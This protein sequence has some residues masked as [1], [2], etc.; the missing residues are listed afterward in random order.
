[1]DQN[2]GLR[3]KCLMYIEYFWVLSVQVQFGVICYFSDRVHVVSRKR[4]I[5]ERNGPNLGLRGK[6]L[7]CIEYLTVKC[8][9]SVWGHSVHFYDLVSTFDLNIRDLCTAKF[10]H[11][12]YSFNYQVTKQSVK[13]S[14]PLVFFA[15]YFLSFADHLPFFAKYTCTFLLWRAFF[16]SAGLFFFSAEQFS[17]LLSICLLQFYAISSPS[18]VFSAALGAFFFFSRQRTK[19]LGREKVVGREEKLLA[20]EGKC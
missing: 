13:A 11:Y 5:I 2:L 7:V 1:M 3:D 18:N 10:I 19:I 9:S 8:S 16:F 6:Y 15:E 17:F 20:T 14:G 12:W 4:L